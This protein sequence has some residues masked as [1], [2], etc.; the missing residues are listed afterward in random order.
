MTTMD[1]LTLYD[2]LGLPRDATQEEI[3]RAY[4]QLVLRLHP[5]KNVN[6]GDTELFIDIHQAFERLSDPNIKAEYDHQLPAEPILDSPLSI[7]STYSQ[8]LITRLS[9]PQ[10]FYAFLEL[11][12][13]PDT[14]L[15]LASTPLN[16]SLVVDCSTSMLGIRLDTVKLTAIDL[17]RQLQPNDIFSLVKFNDFGELLI[18]PGRMNDLKSTEMKIQLLQAGGGTEIY[19]GLEVGFSQVCQHRSSQLINHIILITDGRTYGDEVNCDLLADQSS[20]LGIGISALGIGNEWNDKFLDHITS[21]TGGICKYIS[22]SGDIRSS[23]LD[24]ISRL[25]SILTEQINFNFQIDRDVGLSS[26][27]RLQPDASPLD[28]VSPLTLGFMPR[29]G[30]MSVLFEFVI[31]DIPMDLTQLIMAK[32]FLN[33][34]IPRHTIKTKYVNRLLFERQVTSEPVKSL[35]PTGIF[36]AITLF[37][38]YHMQERAREEMGKGDLNSA[39][40][41]MEYLATHLLQKGEQDLAQSVL[42]EV[43]HMR[44]NQSFSEEGEK[45]I[46]YGTRS[47]LLPARTEQNKL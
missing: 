24:E 40:R 19:K 11:S 39:T 20:A 41:H 38:L 12:I 47:L 15:R 18:A 46:K 7:K 23:I 35:P 33:F 45:R 34:E 26:V 9:E 10:L 30:T 1:K 43:T 44:S 28:P 37:S 16:I 17:L 13:H 27:Y 4:R 5:D 29:H 2:R 14:N 6:K 32:G 25:G 8:P 3:R 42:N 22:K 21:K 31:K 36:N